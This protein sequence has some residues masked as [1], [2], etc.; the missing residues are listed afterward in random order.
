MDTGLHSTVS[1]RLKSV[2][3][4]DTN[5]MVQALGN[6]PRHVALP[7]PSQ[8]D[9]AALD[10]DLKRPAEHLLKRLHENRHGILGNGREELGS[11]DNFEGG[12][13]VYSHLSLIHI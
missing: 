8:R 9:N 4:A 10:I 13:K 2:L 7:L 5:S 1:S 6:L 3:P 12:I 11:V